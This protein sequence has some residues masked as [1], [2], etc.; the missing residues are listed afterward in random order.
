MNRYPASGQ[1]R[2][3]SETPHAK[4]PPRA[5][6]ARPRGN[7]RAAGGAGSLR[8]QSQPHQRRVVPSDRKGGQKTPALTLPALANKTAAGGTF[9]GARL[10]GLGCGTA[11]V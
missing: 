3:S 2:Q 5:R 8:A 6:Q 9:G 4:K 7:R 10:G 1:R 11:H